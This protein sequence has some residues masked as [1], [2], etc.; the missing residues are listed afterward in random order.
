MISGAVTMPEKAVRP[1]NLRNRARVIPAMAPRMV[2][3]E[4]EISAI[5]RESQS[6]AP[7]WRFENSE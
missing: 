7:T 3:T 5:F 2:A 1:R 6:A 4:A